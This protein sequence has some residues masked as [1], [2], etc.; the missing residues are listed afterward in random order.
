M[1]TCT[2]LEVPL[3]SNEKLIAIYAAMLRCRMIGQRAES[4]FQQ[5][6]LGKNLLPVGQEASAVAS[7]IDLHLE[8]AL[9]LRDDDLMP[10]IVKGASLD[11]VFRSLAVTR[12]DK[13][14]DES[15]KQAAEFNRLNILLALTAEGQIKG[16]RE[17]AQEAKRGKNGRVVLAFPGCSSESHARWDEAMRHAGSRNLPIIFVVHGAWKHQEHARPREAMLNGVPAIVVDAGDAVA[18]YRVAYEA[19]AR[20]RQGRGPSIVECTSVHEAHTTFQIA[21]RI[22]IEAEHPVLNDPNL[23][24]EGYLRRK[25]L[26]NELNHRQ[27]VADF[28]RELDLATRFIEDESNAIEHRAQ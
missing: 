26:W 17:H 24:M 20:A 5:G 22:H 15:S 4:L 16:V 6:K 21:D 25:G 19:I 27:W 14:L 28:G 10:G 7:V 23:T 12:K 18:I 8:D 1:P 11:R 3:I 9:C 2:I 13:S